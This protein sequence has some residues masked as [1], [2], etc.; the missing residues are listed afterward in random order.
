MTGAR[1]ETLEV[2]ASVPERGARL[3]ACLRD[4]G[5]ELRGGFDNTDSAAAA[6]SR[7]LDHQRIAD[8]FSRPAGRARIL[9][10]SL[11]ARHRGHAGAR[12]HL[13]RRRLVAHGSDRLGSRSHEYE[14]GAFH[15]RGEVRVLR[16]EAVAGMDGVGAARDGGRDD[17]LFVQVGFCCM[18][19]PDLCDF[20][21]HPRSQHL[22]VG[23]TGCLNGAHAKRLRGAYDADRDLPAIGDEQRFDRHQALRRRDRRAAG[24]PSPG[25]RSPHGTPAG[26]PPSQRPQ[27]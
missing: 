12:R 22:T 9:D 8:G 19:R 3:S 13:A 27:A 1:D 23:G 18:R 21:R 15:H 10:A 11:G 4:L 17:G 26:A 5:L 25:L 16:Q 24:R 6:A 2:K 7:R 14:P 20:V